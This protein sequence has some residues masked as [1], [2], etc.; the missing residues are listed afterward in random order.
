MQVTYT[1]AGGLQQ[2]EDQVNRTAS[3]LARSPFYKGSQPDEV[4]LSDQ[5]VSLL[6]AK[7]NYSANLDAVK[8]ADEMQKSTLSVLA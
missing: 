7:D 4:S 8:V 1:A 3:L 5:V 2:A 6:E